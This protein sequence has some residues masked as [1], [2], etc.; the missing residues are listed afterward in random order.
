MKLYMPPQLL[1]SS[2]ERGVSK[3]IMMPTRN[4]DTRMAYET[5]TRSRKS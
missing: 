1:Y 3:K 4:G 2:R 5:M